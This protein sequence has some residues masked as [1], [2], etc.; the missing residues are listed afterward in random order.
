MKWK[1]QSTEV[2]LDEWNLQL[3]TKAPHRAVDIFQIL[4]INFKQQKHTL[5]VLLKV[6]TFPIMC[7]ITDIL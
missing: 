3:P 6:I 2:I 5:T 4:S 7:Y 1:Q